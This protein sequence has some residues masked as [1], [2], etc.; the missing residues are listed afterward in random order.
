[1]HCS[2]NADPRSSPAFPRQW[3]FAC[4]LALMTFEAAHCAPASAEPGFRVKSADVRLESGVYFLDAK[5]V[6]D[7]SAEAVEAMDNGVTLTVIIDAEVFRQRALWDRKIFSRQSRFEVGVHAL[8]KK[9]LMTK[10]DTGETQTY[11]SLKEMTAALGNIE[12]LP[13]FEAASLDTENT[14]TARV[15]ARLDIEALPSPLRPLA[16]VSQGWRLTSD[17]YELPLAQ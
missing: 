5:I 15:R 17:W 8:S 12:R 14:Y 16:Y 9:Y 4:S 1:M 13:L 7:F 6:F 2:P 11:R 3:L 10:L